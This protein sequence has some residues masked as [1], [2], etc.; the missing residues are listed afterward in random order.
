MMLRTHWVLFVMD[1]DT[2]C[3]II[4]QQRWVKISSA[5][6]E[7]Q[8]RKSHPNC[9]LSARIG[10]NA[11]VISYLLTVAAL[12]SLR[13]IYLAKHIYKDEFPKKPL[14]PHRNVFLWK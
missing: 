11:S 9:Q 12:A 8:N 4:M 14:T 13:N 7:V 10:L 5:A 1:H 3:I 2:Q 6:R